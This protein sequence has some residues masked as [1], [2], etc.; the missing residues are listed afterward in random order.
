MTLSVAFPTGI[1]FSEDLKAVIA[2]KRTQERDLATSNSLSEEK[3]AYQLEITEVA[4]F[5]YKRDLGSALSETSSA[6]SRQT[7][8]SPSAVGNRFDPN[9]NPGNI[10]ENFADALDEGSPGYVGLGNVMETLE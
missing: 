7:E 2:Q 9:F 6:P 8:E 5:K 1:S 3:R 4:T 10:V